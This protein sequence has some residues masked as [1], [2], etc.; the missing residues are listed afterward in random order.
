ML[1]C[2]GLGSAPNHCLWS[3]F[4]DCVSE[5]LVIL[6]PVMSFTAGP[7]PQ[8]SLCVLS[9]LV[10]MGA[11]SSVQL[12]QRLFPWGWW[13]LSIGGCKQFISPASHIALG[14][15]T[16][17]MHSYLE[18]TLCFLIVDF[19]LRSLA[20]HGPVYIVSEHLFCF[21]LNKKKKGFPY[22]FLLPWNKKAIWNTKPEKNR[23]ESR[24]KKS[25]DTYQFSLSLI[26]PKHRVREY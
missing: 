20:G 12:L 18:G 26:Q 8:H 4:A 9:T 5:S 13:F 25:K 16:A 17:K 11:A 7:Q 24:R 22:L 15:V 10:D 14:Q 19:S 3:P 23:Q 6:L 21:F 1:F 2:S